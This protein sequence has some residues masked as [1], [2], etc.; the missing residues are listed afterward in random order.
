M[1]L[2]KEA[3]KCSFKEFPFLQSLLWHPSKALLSQDIVILCG[4]CFCALKHFREACWED[5]LLPGPL[6]SP[7]ERCTSQG[8]G[9]RSCSHIRGQC[10]RWFH[11]T[12]PHGS[13][14]RCPVRWTQVSGEDSGTLDGQMTSL[15][16]QA[17]WSHGWT[18]TSSPNSFLPTL[19]FTICCEH[20]SASYRFNQV[21]WEPLWFWVRITYA[22]E[23][24]K[25]Y[26]CL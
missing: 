19:I 17:P 2:G 12:G 9:Q 21:G 8:E 7:Q 4:S 10:F 15:Q 25:M 1:T 26:M 3:N 24:M 6:P 20:S 22:S 14:L 18:R 23:M 11:A 5:C 16:G 13:A